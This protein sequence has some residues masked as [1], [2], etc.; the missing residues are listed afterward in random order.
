MK[1]TRDPL[2]VTL[3][4]L[5]ELKRAAA[6]PTV[7]RLLDGVNPAY[8]DEPL[9][10]AEAAAF[11]KMTPAALRTARSRGLGPPGWRTVPGVGG[12]YT[13]GRMGLLRWLSPDEARAAA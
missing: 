10:N 3:G 7:V 13:E 4:E 11:L 5:Q 1:I 2:W 9:T 6:L 8:W 12:R